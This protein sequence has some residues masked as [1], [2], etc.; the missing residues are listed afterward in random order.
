MNKEEQL[1][2]YIKFAEDFVKK[3]N[4]DEYINKMNFL[5]WKMWVPTKWSEHSS[6]DWMEEHDEDDTLQWITP[7]KD[8][9]EHIIIDA[10]VDAFWEKSDYY[11]EPAGFN[12]LYNDGKISFDD[13]YLNSEIE[14]TN[15]MIDL[16][17]EDKKELP[18]KKYKGNCTKEYCDIIVNHFFDREFKRIQH[19][20]FP[21][22]YS[23]VISDKSLMNEYKNLCNSVPKKNPKHLSKIIRHFH[24]SMCKANVGKSLS[25]YD[26]WQYIKNNKEAF[27]DFLSN[28]VRCSDWFNEKP[29]NR[30]DMLRCNVPDF[31]YGIGLSTSRMYQSVTYFKPMFAKYLIQTYLNDYA[32][33][34]DPFSGYSGR[35]L[36]AVGAGKNY[37]GQDDCQSSIDESNQIIDWLKNVC[38][39]ELSLNVKKC[40]S[41]KEFG[42]YDCLFTCP[43]YGNIEN[44]PGVKSVNYNCDKWID[45]CLSNYHCKKYLF[46]V[47]DTIVKY[48]KYIVDSIE[49]TSHFAAN[50]EYIVLI[51]EDDLK[52]IHFAIDDGNTVD[53]HVKNREY[54]DLGI[55]LYNIFNQ[56]LF[57]KYI[58]CPKEYETWINLIYD[59]FNQEHPIIRNTGLPSKV[60]LNTSSNTVLLA[61]SGG[62]D[63][64]YQL[65]QLQNIGYDVIL[66]H[67]KGVNT[68]ENGQATKSMIEFAKAA[69]VE[70]VIPEFHRNYKSNYDKSWAENPIKNQMIYFT[71]IDYCK[72]H[73]INKICM[74]VGWKFP[75]ET[76]MAGVD[77]ADA[78]ENTVECINALK[79][80][81]ENL[82]F[83]KLPFVH[84]IDKIKQLD[85][86]GLFQYVY[87]CLGQGKFNKYRH[88][89][90]ERK[91]GIKLY[92]NNCGCYC[93]KCAS[94]NIMMHY[95][96]M[97]KYPEEF[98]DA[99][100]RIMSDNGFPSLKSRYDKSL[101]L[102]KRLENLYEE[103]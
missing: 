72:E 91:Y 99:C 69:N 21:P 57:N 47:D 31:I 5:H 9:V 19:I 67:I 58:D 15:K 94:H 84:K 45:I 60:T 78:P 75:I 102:E 29:E 11:W 66:Y 73:G 59:K 20:D 41:V 43:P 63:S 52:D 18:N 51:T 37:I 48:K 80:T 23:M 38:K 95:D 76:T 100:W 17:D 46:V 62:L 50:K 92:P 81:V 6:D 1:D 3:L 49:N 87:S 2:N 86:K 12:I 93:R 26:G 97:H 27:Y 44:W 55:H 96:G 42:T 35:L 61:C 22:T 71:M 24:K 56:K 64:C 101:P 82:E 32:T 83:L 33:V 65:L 34:F 13:S 90:V 70:L 103:E 74:D 28:R 4:I 10:I 16:Y 30:M 98:I 88:D 68:Y 39:C 89:I 79:L 14:W 54:S 8:I 53:V 25:P 7:T 36:G 40:N 77:V 85:K